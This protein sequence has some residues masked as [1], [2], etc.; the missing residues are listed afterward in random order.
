MDNIRKESFLGND[1]IIVGNKYSDLVLE[2]LGKV[3]IKIGNNSRVLS[4]VL[5][6]LDKNTESNI[7]SQTII[8]NS[9]QEME[10]MDYPGDGYF[11]Y[12]T[13]TTT[14]YISYDERYIALIEASEG[15]K[16]GYVRRRGDV[17]TGQLEINTI[18]PPLIVASSQLVNNLNAQYIGGYSE[19]DLAKRRQDE[20]ITGN[21]TFK[22][23]GVSENTWTFQKNV[24]MYGDLVTSR[25]I[26]TPEF[27]SGF[28]GYGWRMDADTGT[29]TI[30]YL[31]VRK[32]MRVYEMVIN[33]IS[34]TNGSLWISNSSK[35]STAVQPT[36]L[37][38]EQLDSIGTWTGSE[39]NITAMLALL[40]TGTYYLPLPSN[41]ANLD[42]TRILSR[43][44]SS[45]STINETSKTFM[46]YKFIIHIKDPI[47]VVN[48][49]LFNGPSSLYDEAFLT[50]EVA[51]EGKDDEYEEYKKA[52]SLYYIYKE[53]IPNESGTG[54]SYAT[55]F[56]K[57]FE[58]YMIPKE[59]S[60]QLDYEENGTSIQGIKTY[61]KYFGLDKTLID[62]AI[63]SSNEQFTSGVIPTVGV[64]NMFVVGTDDDEYP[65][66]KPGDIIR[67]QK[68]T[69]GN[70]KYYD[71]VVLSQIGS[72]Q[73]IMQKATSVFDIYTEIHYDENGNVIST[74]E[75]YND[76]QYSKTEQSYN[77]NTGME[78]VISQD[79]STETRLDDISPKDDMVQVGNIT[80]V[81]RQNAIYL[82]SSD[83]QGPYI[84]IISGLNRPDYSVL[85]DT[86]TFKTREVIW[87]TTKHKYYYQKEPIAGA[88]TFT[89]KEPNPENPEEE[90]DVTYYCTEHPNLN[91]ILDYKEIFSEDGTVTKKYKHSYTKTTRVRVGNLEGIYN[92][93]FGE[94]Q[95]YGYGLYGEN[96]FLTGEFYLN[97]G[98]S[99]VD[100]AQEGL[101]LRYKEAGLSII[102]DP[103][104]KSKQMISLDARKVFI[105]DADKN[106]G[107]LFFI[108]DGHAYLNTEFIKAQEIEVLEIY[109][110]SFSDT[111]T[112]ESNETSEAPDP[113]SNYVSG[114]DPYSLAK[115]SV[116]TA[117]VTASGSGVFNTNSGFGT[118]DAIST[119]QIHI[120]SPIIKSKNCKHTDIKMIMTP[121]NTIFQTPELI[122]NMVGWVYDLKRDIRYE[123]SE[124]V[125]GSGTIVFSAVMELAKENLLEEWIAGIT[126]TSKA[127]TEVVPETIVIEK[128]NLETTYYKGT[129]Y[130][131]LRKDG[132]GSLGKENLYWD[133]DGNVTLIGTFT[134][135]K[136]SRNMT[137]YHDTKTDNPIYE[138]L[139]DGKTAIRMSYEVYTPEDGR[140][141][142]ATGF[143]KLN[144]TSGSGDK[145]TYVRSGG[146]DVTTSGS[147]SW[148]DA[149]SVGIASNGNCAKISSNNIFLD[150][151][152]FPE[153]GDMAFQYYHSTTE[154]SRGF[155][156]VG[157]KLVPDGA[158]TTRS[159]RGNPFGLSTDGKVY[160]VYIYRSI[161]QQDGLISKQQRHLRA[162]CL[163]SETVPARTVIDEAW[164]W[165]S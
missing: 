108:E 89:V 140:E 127:A 116:W 3:Y 132:S 22:G 7:E 114:T 16:D 121:S 74:E 111:P 144:S 13:L 27:A 93:M 55:T 131:A 157:S 63:I 37:T 5:E 17:M 24:R 128:M 99:V 120:M 70:I 151:G 81:Q 154:I 135:G 29:L 125:I 109:N 43:E 103:D 124:V 19:D 47:K 2:T 101:Y 130:W 91:S 98:D 146:L 49:S 65:L 64:P 119:E 156:V 138:F 45:A 76:T 52:I 159:A 96:V 9:L 58:F 73:F 31:V 163:A 86:P 95:P 51:P 72:R 54:T 85:Y 56:D 15:A 35:C 25:S 78:E 113:L 33:K 149:E 30:D 82:T 11:V 18:G 10:S 32:A 102:D 40:G 23:R 153:I 71:A 122:T 41:G 160:D 90:I 107:S 79:I 141:A 44:L 143:I 134:T 83:D 48:S 162:R 39:E 105:G 20:Y 165:G 66:F 57:E 84:D 6:L 59:Y 50:S 42:S 80:D 147:Y 69:D 68:Y 67:C 104:D 8:V 142:Y 4:D 53:K 87:Q 75:R 28:G 150:T 14:L 62:R 136:G 115:E 60:A 106:I 21:W 38:A 123:L 118:L 1:K 12:N 97:N 100:F 77:V 133:T 34:A 92:E 112:F 161:L 158:F 26:S 145:Y 137:M 117:T 126:Y 152:A 88:P 94:K 139:L 36:I 164:G 148:V 61:Y 129:L 46:N 110:Y 155:V